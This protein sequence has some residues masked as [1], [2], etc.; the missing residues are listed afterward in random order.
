[1][2]GYFLGSKR[3]G[4]RHWRDDDL[5]LALKLWTDPE[6]TRFISRRPFTADHVRARLSREIGTQ[7]EY[8]IQYWPVFL[9]ENNAFVGCCGLAPRLQEPEVPE[10]GVHLSPEYWRHGYAVEAASLVFAHAFD[11]CGY[12]AL[13]AGHNPSN[14]ASRGLLLRLG[15]SYTHDELYPSTGLMHPSY[16]LVRGKQLA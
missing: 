7:A 13:F 5:P 11:R 15:F 16:M 12:K 6:V 2:K 8:G 10:F 3:I 9:V 14:V 1:M 4:L